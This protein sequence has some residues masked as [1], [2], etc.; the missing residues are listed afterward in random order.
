MELRHGTRGLPSE[1]VV[2]FSTGDRIMGT[3]AEYLKFA[4]DCT[5]W[6]A[7]CEKEE[8]RQAFLQLA[9]DWT[10]AALRARASEDSQPAVQSV[11]D[12]TA[13]KPRTRS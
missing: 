6:A 7:E 12:E 5:R 9:K 13:A 4:Q 1:K 10:Q 11:V 3:A 2:L 8:D